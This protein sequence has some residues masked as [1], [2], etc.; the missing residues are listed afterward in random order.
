MYGNRI[1]LLLS[2]A[3]LAACG[4]NPATCDTPGGCGAA[5]DNVV[6]VAQI[7]S[8]RDSA[9]VRE[10]RATLTGTLT[11]DVGVARAT[12]TVDGGAEQA[13]AITPGATAAFSLEVPVVD[14]AWTSVAVHAYDAA[15]NRGSTA[16]LRVARDTTPPTLTVNSP[17]PGRA[18]GYV[19]GVSAP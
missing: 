12:Y 10:E 17:E 3:V 7:A 6:P 4:D 8:P 16:P 9:F 15:G 19:P 1:V 13:L 18:Y 5:R 11:D 2:A 14:T